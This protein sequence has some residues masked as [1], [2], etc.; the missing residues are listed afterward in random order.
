[1]KKIFKEFRKKPGP[2]WFAEHASPVG[3]I[4]A[5][6]GAEG[7]TDL[8]IRKG[9]PAFLRGLV[10]KYGTEPEYAPFKFAGLFRELDGY[11]SSMPVVFKTPVAPT[12]TPFELKVW[13]VL[14]EIPRS[15]ILSYEEVAE[16]AGSPG[17][18]RAA[19]GACSKNPVPIIIPCH[20]VVRSDGTLGGYTGGIEIKKTLLEIEGINPQDPLFSGQRR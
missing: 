12:G 5:A 1:M 10:E 16:R 13:R 7:L 17:G 6:M 19:G 2:V 4:W 18:A 14:L 20:R 11:F 8:G 9:R 15:T 3:A